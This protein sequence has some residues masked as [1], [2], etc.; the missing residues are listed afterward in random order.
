MLPVKIFI[1]ENDKDFWLSADGLY[2][3]GLLCVSENGYFMLAVL[4]IAKW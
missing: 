1:F 4:L 2:R 3:L